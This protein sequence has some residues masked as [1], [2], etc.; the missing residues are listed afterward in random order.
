MLRASAV[1]S[2][3]QDLITAAKNKDDRDSARRE[4]V[5]E[6]AYREYR[7]HKISCKTFQVLRKTLLQCD[8]EGEMYYE[9]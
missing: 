6:L 8:R 9:N 1:T 2:T 5:E 3:F 4:L 7:P